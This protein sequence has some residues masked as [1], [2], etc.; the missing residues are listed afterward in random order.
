MNTELYRQPAAVSS[1][2]TGAGPV[3]QD[4][5]DVPP[6]SLGEPPAF[7]DLVIEGFLRLLVIGI[8]CVDPCAKVG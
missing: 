7:G 1:P 2:E 3:G 6:M 5:F 4:A 8:A